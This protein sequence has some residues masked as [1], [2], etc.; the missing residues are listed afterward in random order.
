METLVKE[1]CREVQESPFEKSCLQ[2]RD[3]WQK[4]EDH[5]VGCGGCFYDSRSKKAFNKTT[6]LMIC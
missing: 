6:E 3:V 2:N 4:E 1:S 5:H